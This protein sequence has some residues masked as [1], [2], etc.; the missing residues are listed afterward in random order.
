MLALRGTSAVASLPCGIRNLRRTLSPPLSSSC[1][2]NGRR[3]KFRGAGGGSPESA[4]ASRPRPAHRVPYLRIPISKA[5]ASTTATRSWATFSPS[6]RNLPAGSSYPWTR[7]LAVRPGA[8]LALGT[9]RDTAVAAATA[10]LF[11]TR[12]T[13]NRPLGFARVA[14]PYPLF[15]SPAPSSYG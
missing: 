13:V 15:T 3:F 4:R 2:R 6:L 14:I 7:P 5:R 9:N 12:T 1:P 11:A 8:R 10:H